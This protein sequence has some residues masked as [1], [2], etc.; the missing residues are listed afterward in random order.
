[1]SM[2][3]VSFAISAAVARMESWDF[4][5]RVN[6]RTSTLGYTSLMEFVTASSF[7]W[8][9]EARIR[10]DGDWEAMLTAV[11]EPILSGETPVIRTELC[12]LVLFVYHDF[13][14][15]SYL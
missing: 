4:R 6:V 2:R 14:Y 12:E 15:Q 13:T 1:M 5:S 8:V 10:R 3:G 11:E 7:D 9:L